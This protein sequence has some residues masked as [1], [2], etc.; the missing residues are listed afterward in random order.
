MK[1][2]TIINMPPLVF[3]GENIT[4]SKVLTWLECNLKH[5]NSSSAG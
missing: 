2:L 5:L 1:S 3:I 4:Q